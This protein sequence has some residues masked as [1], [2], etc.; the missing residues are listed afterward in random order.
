MIST[1]PILKNWKFRSGSIEGRVYGHPNRQRF[2]DGKAI[3]TSTI[4][5][6]NGAVI[7]TISGSKYQLDEKTGRGSL[8]TI[9][10]LF[11]SVDE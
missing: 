8:G 2:H 7:T 6:I 3:T 1:I 10:K 4:E 9:Q 11:G 5:S